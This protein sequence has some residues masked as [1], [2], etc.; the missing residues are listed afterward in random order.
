MRTFYNSYWLRMP[1][2]YSC[3]LPFYVSLGHCPKFLRSVFM[4]WVPDML[5][6]WVIA[7]MEEITSWPIPAL[8]Y[9]CSKLLD[10][11][12]ICCKPGH[13]PSSHHLISDS[14]WSFTYIP[15]YCYM[16]FLEP[17]G[18]HTL[19]LIKTSEW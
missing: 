2:Y 15:N 5:V 13:L 12:L 4:R 14:A 8:C 3:N 19:K 6:Y 17:R 10:R 16:P 18:S 9:Q 1:T 7:L 11:L